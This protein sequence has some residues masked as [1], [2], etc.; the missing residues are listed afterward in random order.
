LSTNGKDHVTKQASREYE[1][2]ETSTYLNQS[3]EQYGAEPEGDR[4]GRPQT[5]E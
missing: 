4:Q 5:Q 1:L 3:E 2:V